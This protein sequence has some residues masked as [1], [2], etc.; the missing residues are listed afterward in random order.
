MVVVND[1]TT[2]RVESAMSL[3]LPALDRDLQLPGHSNEL[4]ERPRSHLLH[5]AA[6]MNLERDFADAEL[7]RRLLV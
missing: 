5:H 2:E 3:L 4:G 7:R 6:S 1:A